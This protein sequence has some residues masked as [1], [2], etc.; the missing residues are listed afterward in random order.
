MNGDIEL[1][2]RHPVPQISIEA[3]GFLD[4]DGLYGG[5]AFQIADH[6]VE[7]GASARLRCLDIDIFARHANSLLGGIGAQQLQLR[8]YREAFAFLLLRR[9]ARVKI[10]AILP[11]DSFAR[12]DLLFLIASSPISLKATVVP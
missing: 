2:D 5:M 9:H 3:V 10:R 1:V 6:G 7:I 11:L 12:T 4:E 8:V